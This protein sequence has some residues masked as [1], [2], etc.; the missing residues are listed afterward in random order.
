MIAQCEFSGKKLSRIDLYP[1]DL[2]FGKPRW[3]RG[4]PVLADEKLGGEIIDKVARLSKRYGTNVTWADGR[5]I[6]VL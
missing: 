6:I 3:Q 5:G 4:R 1:L 2:G